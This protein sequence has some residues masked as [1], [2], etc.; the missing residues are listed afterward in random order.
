MIRSGAPFTVTK[1]SGLLSMRLVSCTDRK[2]LFHESKDI[3]NTFGLSILY[4]A[5][6][7]FRHSINLSMAISDGLP[8]LY[9]LIIIFCLIVD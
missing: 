7:H 6:L 5:T 9:N 4:L 8:L 3:S 2:Y 1:K